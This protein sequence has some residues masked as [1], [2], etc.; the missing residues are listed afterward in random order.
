MVSSITEQENTNKKRLRAESMGSFRE[1]C[2][3]MG[4]IWGGQ[5]ATKLPYEEPIPC[6]L[7]SVEKMF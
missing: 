7:T 3:A 5:G 4:Q 2:W 6:K 1:I